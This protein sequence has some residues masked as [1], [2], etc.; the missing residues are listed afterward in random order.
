MCGR[1]YI[2]ISDSEFLRFFE[3]I[4]QESEIG[5]QMKSGEIFP[6]NIVPVLS[7]NDGNIHARPMIWGFPKWRDQKGVVINARAE[8]AL[9]KNM[10]RSSLLHHPVAVPTSGFFEWKS[11]AG[12]AKKEKYRFYDKE[13]SV[14]YLAGFSN[15][16]SSADV[17]SER[18][19]IL[20]TQANES[21]IPYH[22]R[23]PVLLRETEI[24]EWLHGAQ[25][26]SFLERV[27]FSL[28]VSA[29]G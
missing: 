1:Y 28:E 16:F 6:T 4:A 22:N 21:M 18:F 9:Q 24:G 3:Q 17:T 2:D 19:T 5:L 13:R 12:K 27:P 10:F 20:T 7:L 23:M 25:L 14:L 8:T 26:S 29:A 11:L 15:I